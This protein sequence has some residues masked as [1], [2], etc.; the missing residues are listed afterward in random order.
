MDTSNMWSE[1]CAPNTRSFQSGFGCCWSS[2]HSVI[3]RSLNRND[4]ADD[5]YRGF[6]LTF[7]PPHI[8]TP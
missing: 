5:E 6:T 2:R 3:S 4:E 7:C 1:K 8:Q